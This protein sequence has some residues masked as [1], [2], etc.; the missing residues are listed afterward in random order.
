MAYFSA[1]FG[2]HESLPI[3]SGG[4]G[5]LAG[6]HLKSASDL[7]LPLI[8]IGL[9]YHE[10]YFVQAIDSAGW[11]KE[12]YPRLS[13]EELPLRV[14]ENSTGPVIIRVDTRHGAIHARILHAAVGRVNLYLLDSDIPQNSPEDRRLTARL[15]GGDQRTRIRQELLLGVGG[16][17]ALKALGITPNVIH[18]NEGHSAFAPLEVIRER[19]HDDGL[20]FDRALRDTAARCVFTTHTPVPAGHDRF[21]AGLIEEHLGPLADALGLNLHGMMGLGES[22]RSTRVR[23][24]A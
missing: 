3:Y 8:G 2:L 18:M 4:L 14:V 17:R 10:G 9:F 13:S 24:S 22:T 1:E 12:D 20:P 19:M 21:D 23:P 15:Y 7:G 5:V 11:Q 6:D 16:V